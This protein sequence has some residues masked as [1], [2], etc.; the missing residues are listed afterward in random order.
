M[1]LRTLL[2]FFIFLT[3]LAGVSSAKV[4][5]FSIKPE[6]PVKGDLVT[7]YGT[8]SPNEEVKIDIAFERVV[9]VKNG[10]YVFEVN[11]INI[12][13]K[14]N[15]FT[16]TS[17]GCI[18][19]DVSAKWK[20]ID[21]IYSPWVT[22]SRD[23]TN[24]V[25]SISQ[26]IPTGVYNVLIHGKSGQSSV[27]LKIT[28]TGYITADGNGK[29]SYSYDTSSMPTGKFTVSAGDLTKVITLLTGSSSSSTASSTGS[30]GSGG[31]SSAALTPTP[32]PS[33]T[34]TPKTTPT[35]VIT[36]SPKPTPAVTKTHPAETPRPQT[37]VKTPNAYTHNSTQTPETSNPNNQKNQTSKT[38][39]NKRVSVHVPGFEILGG[40]LGLL[41]AV[42]ASKRLKY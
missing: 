2:L 18:D 28:A 1:R 13:V 15:R 32:S 3:A 38:N 30:S 6:N 35:P 31:G 27:K 33:P 23:A 4:I 24:G 16:V 12:P 25:A 14:K 7:I 9:Q 11:G 34:P 10:E 17:Y 8:A 21:S 36:P 19:L 26:S 39:Q 41:L 20:I 22:L 29:F 37:P 5:N 40:I 42:I